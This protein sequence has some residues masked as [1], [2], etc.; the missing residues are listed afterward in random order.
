MT[1]N[2]DCQLLTLFKR[3]VRTKLLLDSLSPSKKNRHHQRMWEPN[4]NPIDEAVAG[5][6]QD[7]KVIMKS[8]VGYDLLEGVH[9]CV[10]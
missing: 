9:D 1:R 4:L 3:V 7:G 5:S 8:R 2:R 6:L 10:L